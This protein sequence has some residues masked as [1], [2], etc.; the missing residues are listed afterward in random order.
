MFAAFCHR[1]SI[2]TVA[3]ELANLHTDRRLPDE[4]L[5]VVQVLAWLVDGILPCVYIICIFIV[6]DDHP[7]WQL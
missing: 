4:V 5:I 2:R 7:S 3:E 1:M 6:C